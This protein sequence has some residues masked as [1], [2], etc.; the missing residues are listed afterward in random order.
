MSKP[1]IYAG[2]TAFWRL[3]TMVGIVTPCNVFNHN[4]ILF[5]LDFYAEPNAVFTRSPELAHIFE[6]MKKDIE[7][8]K[9]DETIYCPG[10]N[11]EITDENVGGYQTFCARCVEVMP[12]FPEG[13]VGP[14]VLTGTYPNFQWEQTA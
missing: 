4:D 12:E 8:G 13:K 14:F 9:A 10:C 7:T 2:E 1:T 11:V 5:K 3:A 6:Q